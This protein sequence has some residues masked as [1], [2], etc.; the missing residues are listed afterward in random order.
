M[1]Y[2]LDGCKDCKWGRP[3]E[4]YTHCGNLKRAWNSDVCF[5]PK[6]KPKKAKKAKKA[7]K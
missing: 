7:K 1:E 2:I 4:D 6:D 5:V 3:R